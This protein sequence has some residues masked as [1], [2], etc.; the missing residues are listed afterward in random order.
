MGIRDKQ[1]F[2]IIEV[3]LFLAITGLL[4]MALLGGWT[5]MIDT[6]RYRDSNRSLQSFL[7]QQYNLVYN[8]EN[9][10][11]N[12]NCSV[13]GLGQ[14]DVNENTGSVVA[15]GQSK[16]VIMG[17]YITVNSDGNLLTVA[18][19]VG[20]DQKRE[21]LAGL[22]G[23]A[24]AI[25]AYLPRRIY[26]QLSLSDNELAIPW[27]AK[28]S[29]DNGSADVKRYAIVIIRA[30]VSGVVHT[31]TKTLPIDADPNTDLYSVQE[32]LNGSPANE[33][34]TINLCLNP[35]SPLSG[36]RMGVAIAPYAS[37]QSAVT[38]ISDGDN[39]C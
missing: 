18:S 6:Q 32:I 29:G 20:V 12:A 27:G 19:I 28:I 4:A 10:L 37:S 11:S 31:Y 33:S 3:M 30:P 1:G 13:N 15:R 17:R 36:G 39:I 38:L 21:D 23:D 35:D 16:C 8:V 14:V 25:D 26:A 2:T 22:S 7:Q 34:A 9:G 24:E 5:K